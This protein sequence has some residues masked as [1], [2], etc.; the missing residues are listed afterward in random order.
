MEKKSKKKTVSS[1][2][3][4]RTFWKNLKKIKKINVKF[5][6]QESKRERERETEKKIENDFSYEVDSN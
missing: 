3:H 6:W 4:T 2:K 5:M 1:I